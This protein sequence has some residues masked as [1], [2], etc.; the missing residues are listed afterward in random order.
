MFQKSIAFRVFF[1]VSLVLIGAFIFLPL[2]WLINTALKPTNETFRTYFF[3]GPLT[4]DN[5]I[6]ILTDA[7]I[8][9]YL[10]NSLTVSFGS[11]LMATLVCAFAGYSFAKFRY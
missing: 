8:M 1:W 9:R 2:L 10:K 6:H 4:L 3:V 7:K 5:I 11:S